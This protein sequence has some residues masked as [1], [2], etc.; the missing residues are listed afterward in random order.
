ML[1]HLIPDLQ[2]APNIRE[3][4]LL[5][6]IIGHPFSEFGQGVCHFLP[7]SVHRLQE[8]I[9]PRQ[10][11]APRGGSAGHNS[12][13]CPAKLISNFERMFDAGLGMPFRRRQS[14]E[15]GKSDEQRDARQN[16]HDEPFARQPKIV[17][18]A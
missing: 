10:G 1:A 18:I 2:H 17:P 12:S 14:V 15:R 13:E 3:P 7:G 8:F 11:E 5:G 16:R 6:G 4:R 9:T